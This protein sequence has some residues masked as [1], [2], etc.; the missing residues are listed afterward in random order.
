[1]TLFPW[2][3]RPRQRPAGRGPPAFLNHSLPAMVGGVTTPS[4][5]VLYARNGPVQTAA[6]WSSC[7]SKQTNE[8][9]ERRR[10]WPASVSGEELGPIIRATI[11]PKW[12]DA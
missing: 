4:F 12:I 8:S 2:T 9:G 6:T 7:G 11:G 1:M 3:Y 5:S 10:R